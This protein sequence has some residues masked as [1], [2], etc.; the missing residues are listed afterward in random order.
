MTDKRVIEMPCVHLN[1]TSRETL[2][3]QRMDVITSI[4][5]VIATM[6]RVAPNARDYYPNDPGSYERARAQY[7]ARV[8]CMHALLSEEVKILS[9]LDK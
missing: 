9:H 4:K 6:R 5:V 2:I 3:D 1:G 8:I 7:E